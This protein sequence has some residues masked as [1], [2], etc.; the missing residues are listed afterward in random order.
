MDELRKKKRKYQEELTLLQRK[1]S[2]TK[3][4]KKCRDSKKGGEAVPQADLRQFLKPVGS[5]EE[6]AKGRNK[7]AMET[8]KAT[9]EVDN[10]DVT[11]IENAT[12][13]VDD[14]EVT[15]IE[16]VLRE[17]GEPAA[18]CGQATEQ[19]KRIQDLVVARDCDDIKKLE[20]NKE[21]HLKENCEDF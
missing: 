19:E 10:K 12:M 15:E 11:E 17:A 9:V 14:Q 2:V 7:E 5:V 20:A 4:V 3:R 16:K 21:G 18:A 6:L 8:E 13:A 1:E